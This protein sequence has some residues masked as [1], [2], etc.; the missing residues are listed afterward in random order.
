MMQ[1]LAAMDRTYFYLFVVIQNCCE[2]EGSGA[3]AG[4]V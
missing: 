2:A 1:V 4:S 3:T